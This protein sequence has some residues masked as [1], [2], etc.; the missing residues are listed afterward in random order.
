MPENQAGPIWQPPLISDSSESAFQ[1]KICKSATKK[2]IYLLSGWKVAKRH[3]LKVLLETFSPKTSKFCAV[4]KTAK[5]ETKK[6]SDWGV[7]EMT[8]KVRGYVGLIKKKKK[9]K[10]KSERFNGPLI[11]SVVTYC[12][13]VSVKWQK[14]QMVM[15]RR[16][17]ALWFCYHWIRRP[18]FP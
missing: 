4:I 9:K 3:T 10:K 12:L 11:V 5:R 2:A 15:H 7:L 17:I 16:E 6:W 8:K 18:P 14:D 1:S 13:W